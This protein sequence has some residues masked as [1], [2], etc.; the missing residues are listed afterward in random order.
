[1]AGFLS[2][3][4]LDAV[5]T[6]APSVGDASVECSVTGSPDGEVKLYA[7]GTEIG[8]GA[9]SDADVTLTVPYADAVA[10][11]R[12]ELEPS[13]AFMQGRMKTGGDPGKLLELLAATA[14]A[15]FRDGLER[16][17]RSTEF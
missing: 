5:R 17:A 6:A 12:G 11:A 14:T 15:S 2:S 7:K 13:V 16:V 3:E 10:I 9:L 1:V 4:W 8:F